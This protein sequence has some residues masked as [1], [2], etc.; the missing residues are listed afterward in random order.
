MVLGLTPVQVECFNR[1]Q[2]AEA[3][4]RMRRLHLNEKHFPHLRFT[5]AKDPAGPVYRQS[6]HQ[7]HSES[8]GF[9]G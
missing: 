2:I 5:H 8:F 4:L 6:T 1:Q 3:Q 7:G 9:L